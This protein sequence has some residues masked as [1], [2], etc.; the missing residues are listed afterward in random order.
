MRNALNWMITKRSSDPKNVFGSLEAFVGYDF[1]RIYQ[2]KGIAASLGTLSGGVIG[3]RIKGS[4]I[5]GELAFSR[6]FQ[7]PVSLQGE[8]TIMN[9]RLGI[10]I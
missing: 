3:M 5:F 6:S 10:K 4:T 7:R 8:G 9:F 1:G 2:G